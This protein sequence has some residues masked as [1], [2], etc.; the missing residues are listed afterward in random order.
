MNNCN[1]CPNVKFEDWPKGRTALRCFND[2]ASPPGRVITIYKQGYVFDTVPPMICPR[3]REP[4][5]GEES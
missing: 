5:Y 4:R 1:N 2:H 3:R